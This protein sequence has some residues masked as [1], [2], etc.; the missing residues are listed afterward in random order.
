M[1][2]NQERNPPVI[3][4]KVKAI[5]G[6]AVLAGI[7]GV[8]ASLSGVDYAAAFGPSAGAVAAAVV[9]YAVK[10]SLPRLTSYISEAFG[11]TI[12]EQDA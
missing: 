8:F 11:I 1:F 12:P 2:Q 3:L 10:E 6:L 7:G 4:R 5:I 9:A